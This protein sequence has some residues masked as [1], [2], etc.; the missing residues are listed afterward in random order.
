[1]KALRIVVIEDDATI[2]WL[3]AETLIGMGHEV[4]AVETTEGGAVAAAARHGPDLMIVDMHLAEGS[5]VSAMERI[6]RVRLV[7]HLFISGNDPP[8]APGN[9]EL[10]RKPFREA[11]LA[12]A[13]ARVLA[14]PVAAQP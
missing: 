14:A 8:A 7:P 1:M 12:A 4:C 2:G 10:L 6:S 11:E 3:L 13:I 9:A 5:G